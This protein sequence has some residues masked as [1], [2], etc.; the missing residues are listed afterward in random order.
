MGR[1]ARPSLSVPARRAARFAAAPPWCRT[2][3]PPPPRTRVE[4]RHV[5]LVLGAGKRAHQ[6]HVRAPVHFENRVHGDA[7]AS[8][9][10]EQQETRV[11]PTVRQEHVFGRG[12]KLNRRQAVRRAHGPRREHLAEVSL[13]ERV[14][15]KFVHQIRDGLPGVGAGASLGTHAA[16]TA[17]QTTARRKVRAHLGAQHR[18]RNGET[19]PS[20]RSVRIRRVVRPHAKF[21]R[22]G[23]VRV[24]GRR[25]A[26]SSDGANRRVHA[27]AS[28]AG[29]PSGPTTRK[30][31]IFIAPR[32]AASASS[33]VTPPRRRAPVLCPNR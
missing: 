28:R 2:P 23:R 10:H 30:P 29:R 16:H 22:A 17:R 19:R 5:H 26:V 24:H 15:S 12:R 14:D 31:P 33:A 4:T 18:V 1:A 21:H 7:R 6:S 11:S 27:A 8:V 3:R 13:L 20:Q 25:R 9:R 32:Y